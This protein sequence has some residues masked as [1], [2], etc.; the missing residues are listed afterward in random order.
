MKDM[1]AFEAAILEAFARYGVPEPEFSYCKEDIKF[2]GYAV[3]QPHEDFWL[4]EQGDPPDYI[5]EFGTA[6]ALAD[7]V[8]N[9]I[10]CKTL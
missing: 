6:E 2:A 4:Y 10:A 5:G 9:L 7:Y 1:N 8:A 3:I